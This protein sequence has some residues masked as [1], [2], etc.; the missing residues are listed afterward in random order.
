MAVDGNGGPMQP[1]DDPASPPVTADDA[2]HSGPPADVTAEPEHEA[3]AHT[4]A[5]APAA[6]AAEPETAPAAPAE[7]ETAPAAPAEPETAPAAP[8]EPEAAAEA[9]AA[10]P[11]G[12]TISP[13]IPG[14]AAKRPVT[15]IAA[16]ERVPVRWLVVAGGAVLVMIVAL[17]AV[18]LLTGP[19]K[20]RTSAAPGPGTAGSNGPGAPGGA[21]SGTAAPTSPGG[22]TAPGAAGAPGPGPANG[23]N[24][25]TPP[26]SVEA[27]RA[28]LI[29]PPT[30]EYTV[31]P[32]GPDDA[33][34]D[35]ARWGMSLFWTNPVGSMVLTQFGTTDQARNALSQY[36]AG[37]HDTG[38]C[39]EST[40]AGRADAYVCT[41]K[42]LGE[43]VDPGDVP[44]I[45]LGQ[46]GT[47]V[48]LVTVSDPTVVQQL[49]GKQ[50]DRLP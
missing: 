49:L 50:L 23:G 27:L 34:T 41:P 31:D 40:M 8:A 24:P 22:S 9:A 21:Q 13:V 1:Q 46:K 29:D 30:T 18:L 43:G 5:S 47:I 11:D 44:A 25:G 36:R 19:S 6:T 37:L 2:T 4:D 32:S 39:T 35:G 42:D 26:A 12:T 3:V 33:A 48:V 14:K 17:A 28:L 45:G 16:F 10:E 7:P 15:P 20:P 38:I